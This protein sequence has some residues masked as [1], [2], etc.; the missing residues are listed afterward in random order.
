MSPIRRSQTINGPSPHRGMRISQREFQPL[1]DRLLRRDDCHV[2]FDEC[3]GRPILGAADEP[4]VSAVRN[5]AFTTKAGVVQAYT[6]NLAGK[7]NWRGIINAIRLT[8]VST[9]GVNVDIAIQ[10]IQFIPASTN[11]AFTTSRS[12]LRF[13]GTFGASAPAPQTVSIGTATGAS[14]WIAASSSPWLALSDVSGTGPFNLV[15]S[16]NTSGLKVGV[17]NSSIT[18]LFSEDANN[19]VT[20]PVTLWMIPAATAPPPQITAVVNAADFKSEA[21]SPGAW[22]SLF[23]QNLGQAEAAATASQTTLGGASVSIFGCQQPYPRI[24]ALPV[25]RLMPLSPTAW[26]KSHHV[27]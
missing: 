26:Q 6:V 9:P 14:K 17:Y 23:G 13:T 25:N 10:S 7:P 12:Q 2:Y 1:G 4:G 27:R 19:P 15:A 3:H 5:F 8:F 22:I 24:P 16:A 11:A 18:I 20:I 21:F